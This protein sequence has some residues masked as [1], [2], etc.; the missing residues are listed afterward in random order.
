MIRSVSQRV[1]W[2]GPLRAARWGG[3]LASV[4]QASTGVDPDSVANLRWILRNP[5]LDV[6]SPHL[7]PNWTTPPTREPLVTAAG[8]VNPRLPGYDADVRQAMA[9]NELRMALRLDLS[10]AGRAELACGADTIALVHVPPPVPDIWDP[11]A[12]ET[13]RITAGLDPLDAGPF[14]AQLG[15][16][17]GDPLQPFGP[18]LGISPESHPAT[19]DLVSTA[20]GLLGLVIFGI[21]DHL[22]IERPHK[23]RPAIIP[24]LEVPGHLSFPGGHAAK[25]HLAAVLLVALAD[26]RPGISVLAHKVADVVGDNRVR[27]GLHHP[28]DGPAGEVIGRALGNW[29]VAVADPVPGRTPWRGAVLEPT[30]AVPQMRRRGLNPSA[31]VPVVPLW[32]Q[33]ATMARSEW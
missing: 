32:R 3:P 22:A 5:A 24:L 15:A 28:L 6:V 33:L 2:G 30:G 17:D 26:A 23:R 19:A 18:L 4:R 9:V 11:E 12:D 31:N 13:A 27:A 29:L 7:E 25:A 20:I 10:V 1:F 14:L 8:G 16:Q 21:K